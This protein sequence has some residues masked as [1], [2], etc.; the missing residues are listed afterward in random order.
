MSLVS[1]GGMEGPVARAALVVE[2]GAM[3][4]MFSAGVLDVFLEQRF[5]PFDL[6]IGT[7][8]GACNLASHLAGQH[9]RN[10]RCYRDLMTRRDF[11][12]L[13]RALSLSRRHILDLDWLWD[14]LARI[15]PLDVPAIVRAGKQFVAVATSVRSGAAVYVQPDADNMFEALKASCALPWLYR[16]RAIVDGEEL[17]D[18][19]LS[20]PFAAAEAHRRGAR[21]LMV[22]RSRPA[23]FVKKPSLA[24][25]GLSL[26]MRSPG[27]A[28]AYRGAAVRYR[29][30]VE[31]VLSPPAGCGVVHVAPDEPLPVARMT[32]DRSALVRT[33]ELGREHGRRAIE[34]WAAL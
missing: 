28:Q 23:A 6:L 9:G 19:G 11:I 30:C 27:L 5:D 25:R 1:S 4:G 26:S 34:A 24:A 20:D 21:K 14:E 32:Q 8:A 10:L 22:I 17:V 29:E 16:G 31:F 33:Y 7:S 12:D 3:R 15:E 13:R 18:G 2:G